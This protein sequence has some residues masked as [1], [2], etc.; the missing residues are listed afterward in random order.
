[1]IMSVRGVDPV[2]ERELGPVLDLR[3]QPQVKVIAIF[4]RNHL[5]L[6]EHD[7]VA[8]DVGER[9]FVSVHSREDRVVIPLQPVLADTAGVDEAEQVRRE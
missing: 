8:V 9:G 7:R 2:G 6:A 4:G 3:V 1:M 5:L